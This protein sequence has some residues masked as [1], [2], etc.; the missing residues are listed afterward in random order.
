MKKLLKVGHLKSLTPKSC[1]LAYRAGKDISVQNLET[2]PTGAIRFEKTDDEFIIR[3]S[4]VDGDFLALDEE[5][6][7][8]EK[9]TV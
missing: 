1:I 9:V 5:K 8:A 4:M 6:G 3:I 7:I 2:E